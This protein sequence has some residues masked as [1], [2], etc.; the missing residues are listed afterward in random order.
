MF[1]YGLNINLPGSGLC[2]QLYGLC[3][4]MTFCERNNIPVI[5]VGKFNKDFKKNEYCNISE[6]LN[7][8]EMNRTN[9]VKLI[10]Y[11]DFNVAFKQFKIGKDIFSLDITEDIR[12]FSTKN[13]SSGLIKGKS[14]RITNDFNFDSLESKPI[15]YFT[16]MF[17]PS[18]NTNLKLFINFSINN[19]DFSTFIPLINFKV[20][21][22]EIDLS[23]IEL[24]NPI[25]YNDSSQLFYDYISS[26]KFQDEITQIGR[27]FIKTI[28]FSQR[29]NCIHLRLEDD[30]I[31][32]HS[33]QNKMGFNEYK[34]KVE[35]KYI[36]LIKKYINPNEPTIILAY[37]YNNRVINFMKTNGYNYVITP[38]LSEYREI[39]AIND[40]VIGERING[41]YLYV[42]ESS[43][44]YT[45]L[46]RI[47]EREKIVNRMFQLNNLDEPEIPY[48]F[49]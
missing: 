25:Q 31:N 4:T 42:F 17:S 37:S 33:I 27:N 22:F 46:H 34:H 49:I 45:L 48:S 7:I 30:C 19:I 21:D 28:D 1:Y 13:P 44:S 43:F 29:V 10:D 2:N 41:V 26:I 15:S 32:A 38:K 35:N 16:K 47:K 8:E 36:E 9:K 5:F 11:E 23:K 20:E 40:L 24:K 6:I 14:F 12:I 18:Y 39:C 3:G